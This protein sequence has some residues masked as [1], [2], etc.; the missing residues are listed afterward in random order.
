MAWPAAGT[1]LCWLRT[2]F[3]HP[4]YCI[5]GY[6][7][8]SLSPAIYLPYWSLMLGPGPAFE[9]GLPVGQSPLFCW[10]WALTL[11]SV[12]VAVWDAVSPAFWASVAAEAGTLLTLCAALRLHAV[13][14][15]GLPRP[16]L[17]SRLF[18]SFLAPWA[19]AA[20][21]NLALPITFVV[22][23]NMPV[24]H[25]TSSLLSRRR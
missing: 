19:A 14:P 3:L 22:I 1:V 12:P 2:K 4:S 5:R 18:H 23:S 15:L 9:S 6:F 11:V 20:S 16:A 25:C 10:V 8:T 24:P 17:Q 7:L 21:H 13:K